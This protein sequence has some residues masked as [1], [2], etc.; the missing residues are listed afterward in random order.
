MKQQVN[1]AEIPTTKSRGVLTAKIAISLREAVS[2][3]TKSPSQPLAAKKR[4]TQGEEN[5]DDTDGTTVRFI[6]MPK[7]HAY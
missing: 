7:L 1:T 2:K 5:G 6:C 4:A 3:A